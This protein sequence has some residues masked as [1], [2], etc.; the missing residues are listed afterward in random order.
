MKD[1][2]TQSLLVYL[3]LGRSGGWR[4]PS[5]QPHV[6]HGC[7]FCYLLIGLCNQKVCLLQH[8]REASK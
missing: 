5:L 6:Y 1:Y 8:L 2:A 3:S 4:L 7:N